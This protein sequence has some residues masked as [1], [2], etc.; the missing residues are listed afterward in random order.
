MS[1]INIPR[2]PRIYAGDIPPEVRAEM[3]EVFSDGILRF[4]SDGVC[5]VSVR[6]YKMEELP[7][8]KAWMLENGGWTQEEIDN[9]YL[10]PTYKALSVAMTGT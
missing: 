1:R 10:P 8:F 2:I 5:V 3:E 6:P 7:L 9:N 4:H